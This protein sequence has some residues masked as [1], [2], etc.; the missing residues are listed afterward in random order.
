[1]MSND[2]VLQKFNDDC[3]L[4]DLSERTKASYLRTIYEFLAFSGKNELGALTGDDLRRWLLHLKNENRLSNATTNQYNSACKF[5]LR[6]VLDVEVK[7]SQTPNAKLK[8]EVQPY[9]SVV[10]VKEFFSH[11]NDIMVFT[12]FLLLYSTGMRRFEA[13]NVTPED[14]HSDVNNPG[15]D[16]IIVRHGKGGHDRRVSLPH[17]TYLMMRE[18]YK[19]CCLPKYRDLEEKEKAEIKS[20]PLFPPVINGVSANHF[21][22]K[23]FNNVRNCSTRFAEFHPH[24]LRHSFAVH[25][26]QKDIN[27]LLYVKANLGHKSLASTE[28][29]LGDA[30]L[31]AVPNAESPIEVA[32]FLCD[33][34]HARQSL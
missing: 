4:R 1:M 18:Y 10:D 34:F 9:M 11:F 7:D 6:N 21:F 27:N 3:L 25:M 26:L 23:V 28:I 29:Y 15:S 13:L 14:I 8:R 30:V 33:A 20:S 12:Y 32:V 5:L 19:V 31:Y 22:T 24:T 17:A 16:Y 2:E